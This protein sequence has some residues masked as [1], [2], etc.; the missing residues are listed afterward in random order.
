MSGETSIAMIIPVYNE[1]NRWNGAYW[2]TLLDKNITLYFVNDGSIDNTADL[3]G[4]L[5]GTVVL[6]LPNNVGKAEA[7][8]MGMKEALRD[9]SHLQ[10]IGF[11][12]ADG[13]F[14]VREVITILGQ[15]TRLL[16]SDFDALWSSRVKLAGRNIVR[17]VHRHQLGRLV[18]TFLATSFRGMPYDSQSGLKLYKVNDPLRKSLDYN[19]KTR[20]FF[21]LEH[22]SNYQKVNSESLRIWEH[23]VET[24]RDVKGSK[25]YQFR[26]IF[27][28]GEVLLIWYLL[29]KTRIIKNSQES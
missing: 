22:F 29:R 16:S 15:A 7:V 9:G 8:R 27:I 21:E 24:W 11:L 12:D 18:S 17:N 25:L 14:D 4:S 1:A 3:V 20:W 2:Q 10:L 19:S 5:P 26:S 6:N 13:A 23:P 28:V